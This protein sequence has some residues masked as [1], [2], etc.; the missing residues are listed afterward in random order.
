MMRLLAL[1]R[2]ARAGASS[3]YR[4]YQYFPYLQSRDFQI[5]SCPLLEDRYIQNLNAGSGQSKIMIGMA[6]LRRV[7]AL[8]RKDRFDLIWLQGEVFPWMPAGIE[9]VL[10][11]AGVPY[12]VDY[13]DAWFHRYDQ[14]PNKH[15][16]RMLGQKIDAVMRGAALVAAGNQYIAAR[17]RAAGAKHVAILPTVV[18]LARYPSAPMTRPADKFVI[19]WIGSSSTAKY[20]LQLQKPL[21]RLCSEAEVE[22][23]VVGA[24]GLKMEGVPLRELAWSESSEVELM[25]GFDVGVMPLPDTPW[26]RGKCGL[27][28]IQYMATFL[29]VIASPVGVNVEIVE[30]GQQG[31]LASHDDDW[32]AHLSELRSNAHLRNAMGVAGRNRVEARYSL[33]QAAPLLESLLVECINRSGSSL[34]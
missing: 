28:L 12:V 34:A 33:S 4:F 10:M 16:R 7:A 22:L 19:G 29:P 31:Y 32:V 23:V 5:E 2:Y 27:K 6:Y 17:A 18:D 26:E 3:R 9:R 14:H 20:L 21:Q 8:L 11:R 25:Q 15:V 24:T 30:P 13:D 1:P